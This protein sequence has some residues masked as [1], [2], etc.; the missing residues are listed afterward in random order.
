MTTQLDVERAAMLLDGH[1][2]YRVLRALPPPERFPLAEPDGVVRT[3]AVIDVET[4]G[5]E[6]DHPIIDLAIQR[7]AFDERGRIVRVGRMRQ[8]LE[9]PGQPIP[10]EIERLTGIGDADVAG[11]RIDEIE[12]AALIA[13]S[14]VAIAHNASFDSQ[15][16]E[17]RLP[18]VAGHPWA[19]SCNE[20][21][22]PDCGLDGRK[23]GHLLMQ[24]GW[25]HEGH[26]A[27]SDVWA[28]VNLL[29]QELPDGETGLLKLIRQAE[30]PTIRV[31]ADRAPFQ[32]KDALKGRSYR[33]HPLK[34]MWWTELPPEC[35]DAERDWLKAECDCFFPVVGPVT[36]RERHRS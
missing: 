18:A 11:Q 1:T 12:A 20:V 31:A 35:E 23:L 24:S 22:W 13:N 8:W 9:D 27:A 5:L 32:A 4:V 14:T 3:A 36:W 28:T 26:R 15:R 10:P 25:F 33:W 17:R 16:V 21:P 2:G 30:Q 7:I 29:S 6:L 34:R 19:C